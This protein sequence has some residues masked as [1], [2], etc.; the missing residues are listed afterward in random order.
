MKAI[1]LIGYNAI[2]S[3]YSEFHQTPLQNTINIHPSKPR[4]PSQTNRNIDQASKEAIHIQITSR[5][6]LH[7]VLGVKASRAFNRFSS[8]GHRWRKP[9]CWNVEVSIIVKERV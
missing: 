5:A 3:N 9:R 4:C 7:D 2:K 6:S 8:F 1:A